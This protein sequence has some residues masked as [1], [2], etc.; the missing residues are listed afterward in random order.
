MHT[1][2]R[3]VDL[4]RSITFYTGALGMTLFRTERYPEGRFTLA[5]V[6]YG[7]EEASAVIELTHNWAMADYEHGNA[8]GHI[9][10]AV[11]D[12]AAMCRSLE[13]QG[14]TIV[15]KAAPMTFAS[16]DR[17]DAEVI[18]FLRDPDGYCIELIEEGHVA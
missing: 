3:V 17:A 7:S 8:Y 1:M 16:P 15:R 5:F 10:I 4:E 11:Q 18:A 13:A 6:G 12:A 2:L 14:V 9:A